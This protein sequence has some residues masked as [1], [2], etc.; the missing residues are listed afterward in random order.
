ML[1]EAA[2]TMGTQAAL[3]RL[4]LTKHADLV[5]AVQAA[6]AGVPAV[7]PRASLL[8]RIKG[9]PGKAG[10]AAGAL[11]GAGYLAH[12]ASQPPQMEVVPSAPV[13]PMFP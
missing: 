2:L 3:A 5:R 7:A 4:G 8:S 11:M 9:N 10:L 1:K 12:K 6:E 13:A